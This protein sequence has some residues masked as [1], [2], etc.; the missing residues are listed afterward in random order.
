M[1]R[2]ANHPVSYLCLDLALWGQ[3]DL[4]AHRLGG[5]QENLDHRGMRG[6]EE[7]KAEFRP[8]TKEIVVEGEGI[9]MGGRQVQGV[10]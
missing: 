9:W 5:C 8:L 7:L 3:S 2:A 6:A 1:S 4:S 10:S